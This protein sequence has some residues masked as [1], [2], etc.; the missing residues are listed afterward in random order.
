[1]NKQV[2]TIQ[3]GNCANFI[4]SHF[5]NLQAANLPSADRVAELD[6][7]AVFR[8]SGST[9]SVR[10]TPRLQIIDASGAFGRL[11]TQAGCILSDRT[12]PSRA[13]TSAWSGHQAIYM[14]DAI[15]PAPLMNNSSPASATS[16]RQLY[17]SDNLEFDLHP[18]AAHALTGVHHNV[19]DLSHFSTGVTLATPARLEDMF[20]DLRFFLEECDVLG[21]VHILC[22]ADTAF[23]GLTSSYI[24]HLSDELGA[25]L[26]RLVSS[27]HSVRRA[28]SRAAASHFQLP[29]VTSMESRN[30]RAEARL[31][32]TCADHHVQYVPLAAPP[33]S[34]IPGWQV[35]THADAAL[36]VALDTAT[37]SLRTPGSLPALL[38]AL[39][40]ASGAFYSSLLV[41]AP[42]QRAVFARS[43]L[44]S[45][46]TVNLSNMWNKS[47]L[48]CISK[49][50]VSPLAERARVTEV[51]SSRGCPAALRVF[52]ETDKPFYIPEEFPRIF[53][54]AS[55]TN[56]M[57]GDV[58]NG[59]L[60]SKLHLLSA[61]A[62]EPSDCEHALRG[63]GES[64]KASRSEARAEGLEISELE[65]MKDDLLGRAADSENY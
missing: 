64:L 43:L 22:D 18:R 10:Y 61:F 8:E 37:T 14:R 44:A 38:S 20:S 46:G 60:V 40:P 1:M 3:V 30:A 45:P 36:A 4:G 9:S 5:W 21:G 49:S 34:S 48:G 27:A 51:I 25:N 62:V 52:A 41:N 55:A 28:C 65:E 47:F 35:G 17:W 53:R 19:T 50:G 23:S 16:H 7:T 15:P 29:Y 2:V 63:L 26:P 59:N 11:S 32:V 12:E 57:K 39:R 56:P 54:Q 42:S 58:D 33:T 6:P 31:V 13:D 24:S